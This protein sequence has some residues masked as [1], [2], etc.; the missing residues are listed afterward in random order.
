MRSSY[1]NITNYSYIIS[2]VVKKIYRKYNDGND[3]RHIVLDF[4][5][6]VNRLKLIHYSRV[7]LL[8]H[9]IIWLLRIN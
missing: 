7:K 3:I 6:L 2:N 5:L 9:F 4:K 1:I 8:T